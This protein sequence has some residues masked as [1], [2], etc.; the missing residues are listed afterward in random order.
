MGT[1]YNTMQTYYHGLH[2]AQQYSQSESQCSQSAPCFSRPAD[3]CS[4][5]A[6][7]VR[8]YISRDESAPACSYTIWRFTVFSFVWYH[9]IYHP[10]LLFYIAGLPTK[11]DHNSLDSIE[12]A[13]N[14][15]DIEY[16]P[17]A[18]IVSQSFICLVRRGWNGRLAPLY[19]TTL[20]KTLL[21]STTTTRH[22][23][24]PYSS[25]LHYTQLNSTKLHYTLLNS[26][27][28]N[29][30]LLN[31]TILHIHSTLFTKLHSFCPVFHLALV[32]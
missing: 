29:Y 11:T 21:N 17:L 32:H 3:C 8:P 22:Y 2:C 23:T 12:L 26:S 6:T 18:T 5:L 25:T 14:S 10:L 24:L 31:S 13:L 7:S 4:H 16:I 28:L 30:T 27:T 15:T 19:F 20:H 1:R 9:L